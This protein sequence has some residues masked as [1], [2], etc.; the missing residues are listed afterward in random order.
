[1]SMKI[2]DVDLFQDGLRRNIAMLDRLE[3]EVE[4]IHRAVEGLVAM[5]DELKGQGGS[6]IRAFYAECH[7]PLLQ[8]FLVSAAGYKQVLQQMENALYALEPDTS[9]HIVE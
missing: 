6:A 4:A 3:S 1:M 7:L 2:L 9:G 8:Q 5:E